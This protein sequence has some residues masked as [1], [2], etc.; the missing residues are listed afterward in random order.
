[1]AIAKIE[2]KALYLMGQLVGP[3]GKV[4]DGNG[5]YPLPGFTFALPERV[6]AEVADESRSTNSAPLYFSDSA[7]R[8]QSWNSE[9]RSVEQLGIGKQQ[10]G[11]PHSL[12]SS[13]LTVL[14]NTSKLKPVFI[15]PYLIPAAVM[16]Q[17]E[18]WTT[19]LVSY[20]KNIQDARVANGAPNEIDISTVSNEV[21]TKDIN[22]EKPLRRFL[23]PDL[24]AFFIQSA[25]KAEQEL[26]LNA[27]A[28][29]TLYQ[30]LYSGHYQH[31]FHYLRIPQVWTINLFFS[32]EYFEGTE[33]TLS[34]QPENLIIQG[35]VT[36]K[37]DSIVSR[38][39][40]VTY[41]DIANQTDDAAQAEQVTQYVATFWII[42]GHLDSDEQIKQLIRFDINLDSI[43]DYWSDDE[44]SA[45]R[46]LDSVSKLRIPNNQYSISEQVLHLPIFS[47]AGR[48]VLVSGDPIC[49]EEA[50]FQH[51]PS[52]FSDWV[53]WSKNQPHTGDNKVD[54]VSQPS[55]DILNTLGTYKG[56][57]EASASG[58]MDPFSM[59]TVHK[60][61]S[62][63][64]GEAQAGDL[65]EVV[66]LAVGIDASARDFLDFAG[67]LPAPTQERIPMVMKV[68]QKLN[69][70][71]VIASN[72][73][74]A[75]TIPPA[76]EH[77]WHKVDDKI[78]TP[79]K[80]FAKVIEVGLDK[81][82]GYAEL[83]SSGLSVYNGV[84]DAQKAFAAYNSKSIEYSQKT[85]SVVSTIA[86]S[87]ETEQQR[88]L[89]AEEA[90]K[91]ALLNAFS[92]HANQHKVL[93]NGKPIAQKQAAK[94]GEAS[95]LTLLFEFDSAEDRL[96]P[97][98][99]QLVS[100]VADYL[101]N[102]T[103]EMVLEIN[104]FTCDVG[105]LEYN[106]VLSEK[107]ASALKSA[108]LSR[109]AADAAKWEPRLLVVGRGVAPNNDKSQRRASRRAEMRFFLNSA[110]D[111]PPCR[112]WL[113]GLEKSRQVSVSAEMKV[114]DE[115]WN[116]AGQAFDIAL[117]IAA[118]VL[119]PSAA[120][121]YSLYWAGGVLLSAYQG[122]DQI[123]KEDIIKY[124]EA[125]KQYS[126]LDVIGQALLLKDDVAF[127]ELSVLSKA[128]IK[129][130]IAL[131]GLVRLLLLEA[132][133]PEE[134]SKVI[135]GS[136]TTSTAYANTSSKSQ[137]LDIPGY[138][139]TYLLSDDWDIGGTWLPSFHLDEAWLETKDDVGS[140][141][142]SIKS[143]LASTSY[144]VYKAKQSELG[145]KVLE[146]SQ[147]Y[148]KYCPIHTLS[149]P[150][151]SQIRKLV[152]TPA[153]GKLGE[154]IYT[155]HFV[156]IQK[157]G[158][159]K[160]LETIVNAG[161]QVNPLDP[162]RVLVILD[163]KDK[164]LAKFK[165]E[166]TLSLVPIG[167]RPVRK[168]RFI[169]DVGAYTTEYVRQL[170]P[171]SLHE[172][173]RNHLSEKGLLADDSPLF[174][175]C[176]T[177][178]Y[179]L[180]INVINGI[181]PMSDDYG[182]KDWES[183]FG[184][185]NKQERA[186]YIMRYLLEVGVPNNSD[187]EKGLTFTRRLY[188]TDKNGDRA[189]ISA[190]NSSMFELAMSKEHEFL[191]EK[192]FL[193]RTEEKKRQYPEL[194]EDPKLGLYV[195]DTNVQSLIPGESRT[196]P[197]EELGWT[198]QRPVRDL[199]TQ[200][201]KLLMLVSTK[202]V[203]NAQTLLKN[204][205]F[206][207][208]SIV[209]DTWLRANDTEEDY[210][211]SLSGSLHP[212]GT[213]TFDAENRQVSFVTKPVTENFVPLSQHVKK[214]AVSLIDDLAITESSFTDW[215][216][217][218]VDT[219][220]YAMEV[221]LE[222]VNATGKK[223]P[224]MR[225]FVAND[226]EQ[227]CIWVEM[228]G[229]EGLGLSASSQKVSVVGVNED[230]DNIPFK[231]QWYEMDQQEFD[232]VRAYTASTTDDFDE[233]IKSSKDKQ[234]KHKSS[235]LNN[236]IKASPELLSYVKAEDL[237]LS[238]ERKSMLRDWLYNELD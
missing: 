28:Y 167:V 44:Q 91:K 152:K 150:S 195:H 219:D 35:D 98:D 121:A 41:F 32:A 128:Y 138:I 99:T 69:W 38:V 237:S 43:K 104:G 107:R 130:A 175:V 137:Q 189:E 9:I 164:Y 194:F 48:S 113:L 123:L 12:S 27:G 31:D 11:E 87:E 149:D 166:G 15:P 95:Y 125:Q 176:I 100:K 65:L 146:H 8:L 179:Y 55:L 3:N 201:T 120:I 236:W 204:G 205:G 89:E 187:T 58:V 188:Y 144:F 1:M 76:L 63:A 233:N 79:L 62:A 5:L 78:L 199:S 16:S 147:S 221:S 210:K 197:M 224:G 206:D 200:A 124:K 80:P 235:K 140:A 4:I 24:A 40:P 148:Q 30:Q 156:S 238:D 173:E 75:F 117:G 145:E 118:P 135:A 50:L 67:R 198:K 33:V 119:G 111:Y 163:M 126:E 14:P 86:L 97:S 34:G 81:P 88:L 220:L 54:S 155:T 228:E 36:D 202:S 10:K 157:D 51:A 52:L 85:Q 159:W 225:P 142:N 172:L 234:I 68:V 193:T 108:I 132:S 134:A 84:Q 180:G 211:V 6:A 131:N 96:S 186:S 230:S 122:V 139:R 129:R 74:D 226:D 23:D 19:K 20:A 203:K 218:P 231:P 212:L 182:S 191:Y 103:S 208:E 13:P 181:K 45:S 72:V 42:G 49:V 127:N 37:K 170:S 215:E 21:I 64:L 185:A 115:V 73:P 60:A 196:K 105:T 112:S 61:F 158:V 209:V 22:S 94:P 214:H 101:R 177:P 141:D 178:T 77:F 171:D 216:A 151:L 184:A 133:N 71:G 83:V 7:G 114:Q 153:L 90:H 207:T 229:K 39:R 26:G 169:D 213:L 29:S 232:N 190:D 174:G 168:N 162:V 227:P 116:F 165:Q 160:S 17:E 110:F 192:T 18:D 223:T 136:D 222:Y 66:K 57:L 47:I 92:D 183:V 25:E 53:D 46:A 82:F 59:T 217:K 56:L 106:L 70:S 93:L 2:N 143:Y 154:D 161:E 102:T 109:L